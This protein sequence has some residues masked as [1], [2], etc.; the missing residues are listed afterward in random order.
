MDQALKQRLVGATILIALAVIFLPLLLDGENHNGQTTQAIEIPERPDVDFKTRR[1]PIGD[2]G[3]VREPHDDAVQTSAQP[4]S[5]S[6][7]K[8]ASDTKP[9]TTALEKPPVTPVEKDP[10]GDW[11]VQVGSFGSLDNANRVS[12]DLHAL[13]YSAMLEATGSSPE[14]LVRVKIGPFG[15]EAAANEAAE[16]VSAAIAGINPRVITTA[17]A[18]VAEPVTSIG[19]VVQ[20]GIFFDPENAAKL[21]SKLAGQG[22]KVYTDTAS[23]AKGIVYKVRTATQAD[24]SAAEDLRDRIQASVNIAGMVKNL[25]ED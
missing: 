3:Q 19:W 20:L 16:G 24:R 21:S 10:G 15:T 14:S 17:G 2:H 12:N 9:E 18:T 7:P 8:P 6:S 4:Q 1:L 22:F 5:S 25:V 23:G 13:G 11:L